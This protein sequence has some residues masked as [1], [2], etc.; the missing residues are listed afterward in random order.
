MGEKTYGKLID[1]NGNEFEV[2]DYTIKDIRDAIPKHCFE[3]SALR[4]LSYVARD[5]VLLGTTFYVFYTYGT[6]ES[7]PSKAARFALWSVYA[8]IQG[9][10]GTEL[11]LPRY[12]RITFCV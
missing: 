7:V 2:P 1:T 8:F 10:F 11:R 12:Q 4:G 3:R 6:P 9:L 5:M